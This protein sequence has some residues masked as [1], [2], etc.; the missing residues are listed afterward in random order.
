MVNVTTGLLGDLTENVNLLQPTGVAVTISKK[1]YPNV[2]FFAQAVTVPGLSLPEMEVGFSRVN[3]PLP[4]D[5]ITFEDVQFTILVDE[6]MNSY[7]EIF[8]WLNRLVNE[9]YKLPGDVL[10]TGIASEADITVNVLTSNNNGN[11]QIKFFSAFPTSLSS[12][13]LSSQRNDVEPLLFNATFKFAY[14]EIR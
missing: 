5:K 7:L 10:R 2:Q 4:G 6:D 14:F 11:K 9:E 1:D 8:A 12:I 13:E 3:V